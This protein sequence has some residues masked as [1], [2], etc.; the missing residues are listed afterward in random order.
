[1]NN[2]T[3][4]INCEPGKPLSIDD[5]SPLQGNL[6]SLSEENYQKLKKQIVK[7]G[8]SAAIHVWRNGDRAHILDGHQRLRTLQR[9]RDE[10]FAIPNIPIVEVKARDINHAKEQ[11]LSHASMFGTF[12]ADGIKL[13]AE[14]AGIEL[15]SLFS[16]FEFPGLNLEALDDVF[17]PTILDESKLD[18]VPDAPEEPTTK[19]GDLWILGNHRLLCGDATKRDD[20]ERLMKGE[21][22]DM[23]FTDPPYGVDYD[24]GHSNNKRR[25]KIKNDSNESIYS[26]VLPLIRQVSADNMCL[27][28]WFSDSVAKTII[29]AVEASKFVIRQT[30]IWNK[31]VAQFGAIGAQ[32]KM[33][34][35]PCLYSF[36]S[37]HPPAWTGPN[38]ETTVWDINRSPKNEFHP[39]QKPVELCERAIKNHQPVTVLDLFGGSGSTLIACE[40]LK[41]KC[42]MSEIDPRYVDVIITRWQNLTGKTALL[43]SDVG[44]S[45]AKEICEE[46]QSPNNGQ[47]A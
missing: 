30:L 9:L 29:D 25:D 24:G 13:F 20:V 11:L 12:E 3:I 34:H 2:K 44:V 22:A 21:K 33:K 19:L 40:K 31:N 42:F 28:L 4:T 5:L 1:M 45:S 18:D 10:G 15:D 46:D 26:K 36:K 43:H 38:N 6:K 14:G 23:V 7:N 47:A 16:D 41:R 32:Y 8:F 37:G 35:E 17:E 39:T 27:Y